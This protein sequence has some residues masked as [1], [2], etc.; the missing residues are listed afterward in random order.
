VGGSG[1]S[2]ATSVGGSAAAGAPDVAFGGSFTGA[3]GDSGVDQSC[4]SPV[5]RDL[6]PFN[7]RAAEDATVTEQLAFA[8]KNLAGDWHGTVKTPWVPPYSVVAS[9]NADGGYSARCEQSSDFTPGNQGCCR[10]F[11]YGSDR[12]SSLKQWSLSSVNGD[13]SVDG[14][15]NVAFCYD[16]QECYLPG[17]QG[18][19]H[20]LKFDQTSDR[21]R[22][23]FMTD[24]GYGPLEFDLERD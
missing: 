11:Y 8:S 3:G 9:F 14:D 13:G 21:L 12:D 22:F 23:D 6:A 20:R 1:S 7:E 5:T 18:K 16:D 4:E 2:G 19:I 24:D 17:W 15:L 10:A